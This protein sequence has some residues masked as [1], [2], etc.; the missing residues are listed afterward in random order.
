MEAGRES[1][2]VCERC[3]QRI[4]DSLGVSNLHAF[5]R[6]RER[7]SGYVEIHSHRVSPVEVRKRRSCIDREKMEIRGEKKWSRLANIY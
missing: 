4:I 3:Q 5:A 7:T 1:V 6:V 2:L